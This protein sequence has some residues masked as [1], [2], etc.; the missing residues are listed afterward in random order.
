MQPET[1]RQMKQKPNNKL[2]FGNTYTNKVR[3]TAAQAKNITEHYQDLL[4]RNSKLIDGPGNG[5]GIQLLTKDS[6]IIQLIEKAK[7]IEK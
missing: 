5:A 7:K 3:Q 6:S 2:T 4:V 1:K